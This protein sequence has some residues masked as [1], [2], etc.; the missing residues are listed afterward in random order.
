MHSYLVLHYLYLSDINFSPWTVALPPDHLSVGMQF[1]CPAS[2]L[3]LVWFK[4]T[5]SGLCEATRTTI[6]VEGL[7]SHKSSYLSFFIK[8]Y[9]TISK[10]N[11]MI[12]NV[13]F[14][15]IHTLWYHCHC[16]E[17]R[18]NCRYVLYMFNYMSYVAHFTVPLTKYRNYTW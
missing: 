12:H 11:K 15:I 1:Q 8:G 6:I 4:Q 16:F 2:M 17:L 18:M 14:D 5:G 9:V 7:I 3:G 13:K 10:C